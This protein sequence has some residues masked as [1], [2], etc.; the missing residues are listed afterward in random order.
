[1]VTKAK[2]TCVPTAIKLETTDILP[3]PVL[4]CLG[5]AEKSVVAETVA[6]N[7][8]SKSFHLDLL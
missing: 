1:M 4:T 6:L 2:S 3:T 5:T 8:P 7:W